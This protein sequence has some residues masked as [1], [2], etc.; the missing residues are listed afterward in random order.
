V[1]TEL[2]AYAKRLVIGWP[3]SAMVNGRLLGL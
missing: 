1:K 3:L 2:V